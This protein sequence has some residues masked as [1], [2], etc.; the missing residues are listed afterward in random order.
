MSRSTSVQPFAAAVAATASRS[1]SRR[2][3]SS[4]ANVGSSTTERRHRERG[5]RREHE[6]GDVGEVVEADAFVGDPGFLLEAAHDR[7]VQF[8]LGGEV[9]VHRAFADAG[10]LGDRRGT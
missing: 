5:Q 8:P 7:V 6:R 4:S 1:A 10:A 3:R 2:S 9:P